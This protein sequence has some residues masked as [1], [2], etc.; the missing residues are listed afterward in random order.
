MD[1]SRFATKHNWDEWGNGRRDEVSRCDGQLQND[2]ADVW[3]NH[4]DGRRS[5]TMCGTITG[6][7]LLLVVVVVGGSDGGWVGGGWRVGVGC[8]GARGWRVWWVNCGWWVVGGGWKV[9][10]VN[11]GDFSLL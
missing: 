3:W 8:D 2:F 5:Q 9:W 11:S 10:W 7:F 6:K 4:C 1:G